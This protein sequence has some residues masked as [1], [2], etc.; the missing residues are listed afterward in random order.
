MHGSAFRADVR[1]VNAKLLVLVAD[2]DPDIRQLVRLRLERSGYDVISAEDGQA[3]L[4]LA[5]DRHPD[6][7]IL[8]ISMPKMSGLEVARVLRDQ[9]AALPVILLTARARDEDVLEGAN[10]GV[11]RYITKPFSPQ[12]LESQV[13]ELAHV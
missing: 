6:V 10:A 9:H 5:R 3:A 7:A 1:K 11:D 12:E 2:D 4:D 8:D 13:R